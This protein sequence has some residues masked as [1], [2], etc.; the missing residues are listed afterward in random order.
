MASR[1]PGRECLHSLCCLLRQ[2]DV[3]EELLREEGEAKAG[4]LLKGGD[5]TGE[6]ELEGP[7]KCF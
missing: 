3:K 7:F 1:F 4:G 5:T 6:L 2:W